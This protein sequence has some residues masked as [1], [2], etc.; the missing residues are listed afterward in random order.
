[1][2]LR[3]AADVKALQDVLVPWVPTKM[4]AVLKAL[5]VGQAGG[6][7]ALCGARPAG[8]TGKPMLYAY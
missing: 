3:S 2:Q 1:M 4:P 5:G 7:H 8:A 6:Q